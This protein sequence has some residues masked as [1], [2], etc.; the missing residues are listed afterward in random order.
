[1]MHLCGITVNAGLEIEGRLKRGPPLSSSSTRKNSTYINLYMHTFS[2]DPTAMLPSPRTANMR[3][4]QHGS[5]IL[6]IM[7]FNSTSIS[8][9]SV[10]T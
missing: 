6:S 7:L 3:T 10:T 8:I 5:D 9:S 2:G 1:M 4:V